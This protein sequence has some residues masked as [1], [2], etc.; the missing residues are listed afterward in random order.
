MQCLLQM[1]QCMKDFQQKY[2][3]LLFSSALLL[4]MW[5]C[6][7]ILLG[8][9]LTLCVAVAGRPGVRLL[10]SSGALTRTLIALALRW[11]MGDLKTI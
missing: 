9:Q 1:I 3:G 10:R 4:E 8:W 7:C 11:T 6:T 5:T 2:N